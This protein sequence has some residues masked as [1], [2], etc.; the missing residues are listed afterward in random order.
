MPQW[1]VWAILGGSFLLFLIIQ[2]ISKN[3]KPIKST[4]LSLSIGIISL[5]AVNIS[6]T[7]TGVYI[8]ISTLTVCSSAIGGIPAVTLML[9]INMFV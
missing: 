3:K 8:P 7:F 6:S 5:V 9:I 1:T 2:I 4:F